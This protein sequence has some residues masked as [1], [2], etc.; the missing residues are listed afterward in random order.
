MKPQR[1]LQLETG[2]AHFVPLALPVLEVLPSHPVLR[3]HRFR[4]GTRAHVLA[5]H[6]LAPLQPISN[7]PAQPPKTEYVVLI[8]LLVM[9]VLEGAL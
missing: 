2:S 6:R 4:W 3:A 8:A 5:A 1:A 9:L 7:S